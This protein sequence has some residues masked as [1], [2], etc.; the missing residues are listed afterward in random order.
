MPPLFQTSKNDITDVIIDHSSSH[1]AILQLSIHNML[2]Q[3]VF[4]DCHLE[5][6]GKKIACHRLV[7]ASCSPVLHALF[8]S[9][10]IESQTGIIP[11]QLFGAETMEAIV[12]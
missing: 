10:M 9:G 8:T 3:R 2:E 11:I 5:V 4:T 12:R 7:L 6:E 1:S